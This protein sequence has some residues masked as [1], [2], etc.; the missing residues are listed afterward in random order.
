MI[1]NNITLENIANI[2][3]RIN[4]DV[5]DLSMKLKRYN[6]ELFL[7]DENP[8]KELKQIVM[9]VLDEKNFTP[10]YMSGLQ[11]KLKDKYKE[12][13]HFDEPISVTL[14][15]YLFHKES[16]DKVMAFL[17]DCFDEGANHVSLNKSNPEYIKVLVDE[18]LREYNV[19]PH[20]ESYQVLRFDG[21]GSRISKLVKFE[22]LDSDLVSLNR[23]GSLVFDFKEYLAPVSVVNIY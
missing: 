15:F 3:N 4:Y 6:L 1:I 19:I 14:A 22:M 16:G 17:Y 23:R 12:V 10:F 20:K 11:V 18:A 8:A 2:V 13:N 7:S 5:K 21:S 9:Q